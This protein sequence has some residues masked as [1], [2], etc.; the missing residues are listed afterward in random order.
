MAEALD[1]ANDYVTANNVAKAW[2]NFGATGGTLQDSFNL[3]SVTDNG[4]GDFSPQFTRDLA[5]ANYAVI[6]MINENTIPYPDGT[7]GWRS[8]RED[9]DGKAVGSCNL[10]TFDNS[11]SPSVKD[12]DACMFVIYGDE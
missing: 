4:T 12:T 11:G 2:G 3:D 7:T 6:A 10:K 5:N 8:V 1:C 9:T